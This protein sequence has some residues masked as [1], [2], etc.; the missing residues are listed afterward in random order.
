MTAATEPAAKLRQKIGYLNTLI[1]DARTPAGE[2]EAAE[3]ARARI[4]TALAKAEPAQAAQW[5]TWFKGARYEETS[6]LAANGQL[7][8][9]IRADLKMA[10]KAAKAAGAPGTVALPGDPFATMPASVKFSVTTPHYG[11][12]HIRITG[13]PGDW[14]YRTEMDRPYPGENRI[15]REALA[16]L[17]EAV[18]DIA[19]AYNYD[20]SDTM[21]DY[22][23]KRYYL[24]VVDGSGCSL[25]QSM[26]YR[27]EEH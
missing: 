21:T 19:N 1:S 13:I 14:G 20:N 16:R 7:T 24:S 9:L 2:R 10:V 22:F 23:C 3:R 8:K 6:H 25:P 26:S 15:Y 5:E 11:S 27:Y 4:A 18:H 12:V 17:S